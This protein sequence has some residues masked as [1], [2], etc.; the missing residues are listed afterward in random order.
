MRGWVK[1][2]TVAKS[3]LIL[4]PLTAL[5]PDSARAPELPAQETR[6][7]WSQDHLFSEW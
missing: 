5:H 7:E 1:K 6:A 2:V 3:V 4:G